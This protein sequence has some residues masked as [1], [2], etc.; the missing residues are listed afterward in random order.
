LLIVISVMLD[1]V[2][3]IEANLVMRNY[4]GFMEGGS[5]GGGSGA[6]LRRPKGGPT[7]GPT[8]P[9]PAAAFDRK[10]PKGLPA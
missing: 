3:R 10:E 7:R 5:G 8:Q 4:G 1:L 6:K 2:N 9:Q